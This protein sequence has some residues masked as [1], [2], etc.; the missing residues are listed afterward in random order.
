MAS[1]HWFYVFSLTMWKLCWGLFIIRGVF[2]GYLD[3]K[4]FPAVSWSAV[5]AVAWGQSR[6]PPAPRALRPLLGHSR[7]FPLS[8]RAGLAPSRSCCSSSL[9]QGALQPPPWGGPA[10]AIL[11]RRG[12]AMA[13]RAPEEPG[14][15]R[16]LRALRGGR[17]GPFS[18]GNDS[19]VVWALQKGKK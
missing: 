10:G 4:G 7:R 14:A 1:L 15:S 13:E 18:S 12:G 5:R 8:R 11:W 3:G 2:I 9:R 17:K 19:G 16:T 6:F